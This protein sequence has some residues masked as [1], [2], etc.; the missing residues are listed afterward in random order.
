M[1]IELNVTYIRTEEKD[2]SS[3]SGKISGLKQKNTVSNM[4]NCAAMLKQQYQSGTGL[5]FTDVL[6]ESLVERYHRKSAMLSATC[7]PTAKTSGYICLLTA[8]YAPLAS[9]RIERC[10]T[11]TTFLAGHP[12]TVQ[13]V[14]SRLGDGD[15]STAKTSLSIRHRVRSRKT[16]R[17]WSRRIPGCFLS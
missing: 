5:P 1:V 6:P 9:G 3:V 2:P 14:S 13:P 17:S 8:C 7:E 12:S 4:S 15:G 16:T 10:H 11:V